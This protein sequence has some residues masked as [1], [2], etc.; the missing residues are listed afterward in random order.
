MSG[1]VVT[2]AGR[3]LGLEIARRLAARRLAVNVADIDA[4]AAAEAAAEIGGAAW[5]T[6]LDVRDGEACRAVARETAERAGSLDVWVNNAGILVTG[7]A[8]DHDEQTRRAVLEVNALG[9]FNGTVAAL[10]LM[11]PADHGHVINIVSLA[12]LVAAP[13]E[14]V[15]GASKHAAIAFTLG[16]LNDLRRSGSKGVRMSAVCPDGIWTPMLY[17]RLDDPAAAVSFAGNFMRPEVVADA[18]VGLLDRPRALLTVPRRRAFFVRF[19][20]LFPGFA[21]RMLPL[22]LADARRKQRRWKQRIESGRG[23]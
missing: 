11:R 12:G 2:G 7:F 15:Y 22:L 8:W 21:N 13:G 20:D 5:G 4:E 19:A 9:T 10:E 1:A 6:E 3:G 17:D 16:A 18:A 23:P 14:A